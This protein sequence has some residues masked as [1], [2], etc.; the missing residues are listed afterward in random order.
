MIKYHLK[1][2]K[3]KTDLLIFKS[4]SRQPLD[5]CQ[6]PMIYG[7]SPVLRSEVKNLEQQY[8]HGVPDHFDLQNLY[9]LPQTLW[10]ILPYILKEV[11]VLV[12]GALINSRLDY[13]NSLLLGVPANQFKRMPTIQNRATSLVCGLKYGDHVMPSRWS[14]ITFKA[15]CLVHHGRH[16]LGPSYLHS[17]LQ[18]YAPKW[19]LRSSD[20]ALITVKR[21]RLKYHGGQRLGA[22]GPLL[23]NAL[24]QEIR[25]IDVHD[26]FQ[27]EIKTLHHIEY[28]VL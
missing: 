20:Q 13:G 3:G 16:A 26:V 17:F 5:P 28:L 10:R 12:A 6:V 24:H 7:Q 19:T 2:N 21:H 4:A 25:M 18:Q 22:Q 23:W 1:L 27:R 11:R 14:K 9:L 15:Q 8:D